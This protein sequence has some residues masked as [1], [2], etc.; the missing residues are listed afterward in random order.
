MTKETY[1]DGDILAAMCMHLDEDSVVYGANGH[2][3][4]GAYYDIT[5]VSSVFGD[6]DYNSQENVDSAN[7]TLASE[8]YKTNNNKFNEA[9]K[10]AEWL[11]NY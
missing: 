5:K 6:K 10:N 9:L 2:Y 3:S 4:L 8:Q 11:K 7:E 1:K